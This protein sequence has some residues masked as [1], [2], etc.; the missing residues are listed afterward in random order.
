MTASLHMTK[1]FLII[2]VIL[3]LLPTK[4]SLA[5]ITQ[6]TTTQ[7]SQA[8]DILQKIT[9]QWQKINNWG[10]GILWEGKLVTHLKENIKQG[11]E[12]EKIEYKQNLFKVL[13]M[14]WEKIKNFVFHR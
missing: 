12:E 6:P 13:G 10:V 11:W 9:S 14:A 2:F 7:Y 1:K 8:K 4:V 3:F 5:T